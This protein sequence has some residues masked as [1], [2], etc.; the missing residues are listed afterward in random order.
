MLKASLN[1]PQWDFSQGQTFL[2]DS[3]LTTSSTKPT[4]IPIFSRWILQ[5][6]FQI[7]F[8]HHRARLPEMEINAD[9]N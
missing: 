6:D 9:W 5:I 8:T 1:P 3:T 4:H 7:K 2:P